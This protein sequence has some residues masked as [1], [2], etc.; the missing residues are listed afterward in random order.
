MGNPYAVLAD[1][2]DAEIVKD[3]TVEHVTEE[4][5]FTAIAKSRVLSI[6]DAFPESFPLS[7]VQHLAICQNRFVYVT[8]TNKI[9]L[10][11][12][13]TL[14]AAL[15]SASKS[16]TTD[17]FEPQNSFTVEAP[18]SHVAFSCDASKIYI[19]AAQGGLLVYNSSA[20]DSGRQEIECPA[21]LE[22][23]PNP[24]D[25]SIALLTADGDLLVLMEQAPRKIASGVSA[26]SWSKKGK[27]IM[28]GLRNGKLNQFT[29]SGDLKADLAAVEVTVGSVNAI[30]WLE[31]DL[32]TVAYLNSE[33]DISVYILKRIKTSGST[34]LKYTLLANPSPS[35]GDTSHISNYS[36]MSLSK[37]LVLTAST[38]S[39]DLGLISL[40]HNAALT[41]YDDDH[42]AT[43]RF[44]NERA[45]EVS[46]TG[47]SLQVSIDEKVIW[48]TD[49]DGCCGAWIIQDN[50]NSLFE[51]GKYSTLLLSRTIANGYRTVD[52]REHYKG[53]A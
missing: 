36:F 46:L 15:E 30:N 18:V 25:M 40:T 16:R 2:G 19:A 29:P 27:Q 34:S 20:P 43:L 53:I 8:S 26:I 42:R 35:Y 12:I 3:E 22:L 52:W 23:V 39:A 44:S 32:L 33:G 14:R 49:N 21:L 10:G 37:T 28:A 47:L 7:R 11:D 50:E 24:T 17:Q 13:K 9:C 48:Y 45:A 6:S 5:S 51:A 1:P 31:N 38:T 41:M 4:Q